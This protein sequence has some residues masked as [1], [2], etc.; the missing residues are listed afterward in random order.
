[1]HP[2]RKT[3]M[4]EEMKKLNKSSIMTQPRNKKIVYDDLVVEKDD[5]KIISKSRKERQSVKKK[6]QGKA[7]RSESKKRGYFDNFVLII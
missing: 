3:E 6:S 7:L 1:M 5:K 4:L 2:T